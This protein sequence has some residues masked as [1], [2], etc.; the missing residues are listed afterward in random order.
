M[1]RKTVKLIAL[2]TAIIFLLGSVGLTG[3]MFFTDW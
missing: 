2:I 1:Q 3:A